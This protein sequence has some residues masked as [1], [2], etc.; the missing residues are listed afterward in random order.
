MGFILNDCERLYK[1]WNV[2]VRQAFSVPNTTHRYMS[3]EMSRCTHPKV[4]LAIRYVG[5]TESLCS[6]SKLSMRILAQWFKSDQRTVM[7]R[8]LARLSD[9][10]WS[11]CRLTKASV[12]KCVK[13]FPVPEDEHWRINVVR[14]LLS[15][16]FEIPEF[17]QQEIQEMI[18]FICTT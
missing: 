7:G 1:A 3:E 2:S 5:F 15:K 14:E 10:C 12:K 11:P 8:T 4:M 6:S 18:N 9:M 16:D 17:T 13:Y